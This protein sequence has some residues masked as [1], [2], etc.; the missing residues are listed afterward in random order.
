MLWLFGDRLAR[1]AELLRKILQLRQPV[2]HR[3]HSLGVVDMDAGL[4]G[5][6]RDRRG[7]DV[8]KS[9]GRVPVHQVTAAFRAVLALAER[10]LAEGRDV[11]RAAR[12]P[13]RL[14]LP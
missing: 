4:E 13:H 2:A 5:E 14:R 9:Y 6:R 10:R 8:D 3:Q 7:I 11:L 1:A 12:D